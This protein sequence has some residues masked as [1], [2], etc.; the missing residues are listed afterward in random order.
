MQGRPPVTELAF[1]WIIEQRAKEQRAVIVKAAADKR[2]C[3]APHAV[4]SAPCATT[5]AAP[6]VLSFTPSGSDSTI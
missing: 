2:N 6:Q 1:A 5:G 4:S 3:A